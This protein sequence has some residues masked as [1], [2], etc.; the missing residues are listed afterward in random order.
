MKRVPHHLL[1]FGLGL[2]LLTGAAHAQTVSYVLIP[3]I[4][5][6]VTETKVELLRLPHCPSTAINAIAAL[7]VPGARP[8][9][10][11]VATR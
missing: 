2:T 4:T 1:G 7:F 5:P 10:P 9:L 6:G 8:G 11:P 3:T